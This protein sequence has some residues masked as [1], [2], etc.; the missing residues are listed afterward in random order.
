MKTETNSAAQKIVGL[1]TLKGG[2]LTLTGDVSSL[3]DCAKHV[4]TAAGDMGAVKLVEVIG[5]AH[6]L[7][8]ESGSPVEIIGRAKIQHHPAR[9]WTVATVTPTSR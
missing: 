3:I 1:G 7:A 2:K 8:N 6:K 5:A 9:V 4:G